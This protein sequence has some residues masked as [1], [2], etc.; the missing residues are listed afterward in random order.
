[1]IGK[2][3][4]KSRVRT[5]LTK[6][7]LLFMLTLAMVSFAAI[8]GKAPMMYVIMGIMIGGL[9][10]SAIMAKRMVKHIELTRDVA[11]RAWQSQTVHIA[12]NLTNPRQRASSLAL[13]VEES[14]PRGIHSVAGYCVHL[15]PRTN[16]RAGTRL[17]PR[18][19]GRII[20]TGVDLST[21]FPFGLVKAT[22]YIAESSS[23]VVWPARGRI[24]KRLLFRGAVETS[25]AAPSPASG[26]QDEFFG[27]REYRPGDNPRWIHWRRSATRNEPV[28]REMAKPL[29]EELWLVFDTF[30]QDLS[31]IGDLV[32]EKMLRFAATLMD[33]AL[34][35]QYNVGLIMGHP[36]KTIILHPHS[37][38]GHR[39]VL[40]DSLAEMGPNTQ[41][42]LE[43]S[44]GD[45]HK[46][47]FKH[48]QV[49]AI[50]PNTKMLTPKML[51]R[52]RGRSR[53]F[54]VIGEKQLEG[55][56]DDTPVDTGANTCR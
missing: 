37:G 56:F 17:I 23:L 24:T 46:H 16:F 54:M 31:E 49:I 21:V 53:H 11:A 44:L 19:R 45:V 35:H 42:T 30:Q 3:R 50:S 10:V 22:K 15:P 32:R 48:S 55:T 9:I 40:L 18:R 27:L 34:T 5:R 43:A 4:S 33:H 41:R 12:Y 28:V 36:N 8:Q 29:P 20:L 25:S 6:A 14:S 26:G 38:R 47:L 1:M 52:L 7:G 39:N 13:T 51:S 2:S